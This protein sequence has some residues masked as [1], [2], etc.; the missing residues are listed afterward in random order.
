MTNWRMGSYRDIFQYEA[1]R[2]FW[3]GFTFSAI[4]DAMTRIAF[5]WFVY[6]STGSPQAVGWLLLCYTGPVVVG[7]FLAGWLLDRFD[8]RK[9]MLID[10]FMAGRLCMV[11][12]LGAMA[13]G[14]VVGAFGAGSLVFPLSLGTLI[15]LAQ[16]LSGVALGFLLFGQNIWLTLIGVTL[17]GFFSAPLTIWAQTLRMDI[18]PEQVRGRTFALL[19]TL[20]QSSGPLASAGAGVLLPMLGIPI[21]IGLS[22]F[23][24]G[25]PGVFGYGVKRLRQATPSFVA[26]E[27]EKQ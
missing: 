20:M 11:Y 27:G 2:F 23:F 14:E 6:Q 25:M 7:G 4:G 10:N 16:V 12:S 9:V 5:I 19:R 17:L 21:M 1:F 13:V 18:I 15:C 8:R 3:L 24:V 22:A 26:V